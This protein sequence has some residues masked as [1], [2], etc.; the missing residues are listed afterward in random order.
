L[1]TEN[2]FAAEKAVAIFHLFCS[3]TTKEAIEDEPVFL[4]RCDGKR[5]ALKERVA[6]NFAG[7]RL[8]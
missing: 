6:D 8:F 5:A 2:T 4:R 1:P 3:S 7:N